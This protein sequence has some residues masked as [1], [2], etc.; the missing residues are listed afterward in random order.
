M[1]S[2][3]LNLKAGMKALW[4]LRIRTRTLQLKRRGAREKM[5]NGGLSKPFS[6]TWFQLRESKELAAG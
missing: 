6:T 2:T 5:Q 3:P 4:G 1:K